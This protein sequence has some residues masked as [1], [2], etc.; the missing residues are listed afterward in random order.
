MGE[1]EHLGRARKTLA[2]ALRSLLGL[3]DEIHERQVG[4]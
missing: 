3:I 1:D 2:G 4:I